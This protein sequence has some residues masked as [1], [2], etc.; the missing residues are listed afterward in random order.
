LYSMLGEK[1]NE[2]NLETKP[3]TINVS[4]LAPGIY[5]IQVT[6]RKIKIIKQ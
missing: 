2:F 5:F 6:D 3:Q 4:D 1:I